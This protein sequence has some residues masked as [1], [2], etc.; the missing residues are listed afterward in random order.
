MTFLGCS[1]FQ[2]C[3][4]LLVSAIRKFMINVQFLM[5]V[6]WAYKATAWPFRPI[7]NI[8]LSGCMQVYKPKC[9]MHGR[10]HSGGG[11]EEG[12]GG[13]VEFAAI[14]LIS[15]SK[16]PGWEGCAVG[17]SDIELFYLSNTLKNNCQKENFGAPKLGKIVFYLIKGKTNLFYTFSSFKFNLVRLENALQISFCWLECNLS[18]FGGPATS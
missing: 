7:G 8:F 3:L 1:C 10:A 15:V 4:Y 14:C 18:F 2:Y 5:T 16:Y 17:W 13:H 9:L 12:G 11:G 6:S